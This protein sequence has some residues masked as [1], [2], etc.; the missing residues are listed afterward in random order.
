MRL[1]RLALPVLIGTL[2]LSGCSARRTGGPTEAPGFGGLDNSESDYSHYDSDPPRPSRNSRM[3]IQPNPVPPARGIS[4]I[5]GIS[6]TVTLF[7]HAEAD[8]RAPGE[9][10]PAEVP[11][12]DE[13]CQAEGCDTKDCGENYLS[14]FSGACHR[15]YCTVKNRCVA[16]G[17]SVRNFYDDEVSD[18]MKRW[19]QACARRL[20]E[21]CKDDCGE[22]ACGD[23]QCG[24]RPLRI[25]P[26]PK[27]LRG[28][29]CVPDYAEPCEPPVRCVPDNCTTERCTDE[30][31]GSNG[32]RGGLLDGLR[33][34]VRI[35]R[36]FFSKWLPGDYCTTE[37]GE[38]TPESCGDSCGDACTNQS[39]I[40][41]D[42]CRPSPI[43]DCMTDPF[44]GEDESATP[45]L[46]PRQH[47]PT[48][49]APP[50][51]ISLPQDDAPGPPQPVTPKKLTPLSPVP[52]QPTGQATIYPPAWP[53]L[54]QSPGFRS[55]VDTLIQPKAAY[56]VSW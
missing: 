6:H 13:G 23:L 45:L 40:T 38:C 29:P 4:H 20:H 24:D 51:P 37:C 1:T 56:P 26:E 15:G 10:S 17:H 14:R 54:N 11:C 42:D 22:D 50:E 41:A 2:V 39:R 28:T 31:C 27:V 36:Y 21:F 53:R 16:G 5:R 12:T 43:A 8:C 35:N 19:K 52:E 7:G 25:C 30:G 49:P 18:R 55:T 48:E 3:A 47:D 46:P 9:C 32:H 33:G 34:K 44:A